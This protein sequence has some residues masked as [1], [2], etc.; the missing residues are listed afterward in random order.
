M[1]LT[2]KLAAGIYPALVCHF[3]VERGVASSAEMLRSARVRRRN[4]YLI[5]NLRFVPVGAGL[6]IG[7]SVIW[8]VWGNRSRRIVC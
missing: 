5:S 8:L 6:S 4:T 2:G 3:S 1:A 7:W